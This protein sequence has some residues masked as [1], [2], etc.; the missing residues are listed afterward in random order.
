[1]EAAEKIHN[2]PDEPT[3]EAIPERGQWSGRFDFLL[4]SLGT[5]VG[6]GNVWRFPYLCY[7]NGG[8][9][10]L[11]PYVIMVFMVGL[12]VFLVELTIGQ[13]AA[14]SPLIIF[15]NIAP[16]FRGIGIAQ[17]FCA[18]FVAIYYNMIIAWTLFYF[19]E[20]FRK[21]VPWQYCDNSFNTN[22]CFDD[23]NFKRCKS[24]NINNTFFNR[25]CFNE[26]T[27]T[28]YNYSDIPQDKRISAPEEYFNLYALGKSEGLHDIGNL[29]WQLVCSL[30]GAWVIVVCC[31]IKGIKTSGRVVYFTATFPYV[32]LLILFFRGVTLDGA[33][34]GIKFYIIPNFSKLGDIGVWEDATIQV[35]YSFSIAGG[36]MI[37]YASYN[38]FHN[39]LIKDTLIIGIG[40]MLTSIF[41]GFVVFSVLGFMAHQ[42]ET[43][44]EDVVESGTGLAFIVYPDGITR[45]PLSILWGLLFFFML[46]LLGIDSQFAMVET[47]ITFA[48]DLLP[49][50]R[51]RKPLVVICIGTVLFLFGLPLCTN[52]GVYILEVIDAYAAGWPFMF[53]GLL[54]CLV[55]A[56][57]YGIEN[58]LDDLKEMTGWSPGL[59]IRSHLMTV[60]MTVSPLLIA[61]ILLLTWVK[62]E[63][64]KLGNY[65]FPPA[66]NAI[67]W[68]LALIPILCIPTAAVWELYKHR[69]I[70]II[71]RLK[72]LTKPTSE[73][74]ANARRHVSGHGVVMDMRRPLENTTVTEKEDAA[75]DNPAL[76]D[77]PPQYSCQL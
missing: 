27:S 3:V 39:N 40:D 68:I 50:T 59:W 65:V 48:F 20:C 75:Y 53:V 54:E 66:G 24:D 41:S 73:W 67:G 2:D 16:I 69:D 32:I 64:L 25:T 42:L 15:R 34:E 28:F 26:T 44:V 33:L 37:T 6:L 11:V 17:I 22:N 47:I 35:F 51:T 74:R 36:S 43:T 58:F 13:F 57:V 1:M 60:I 62:F 55:I 56:Y 52:G 49:N 4:A 77:P 30:L 71:Q 19:F 70:P 10:F 46:F 72:F 31:L 12:P 14:L 45:M 8:G 5:A 29:R 23:R 7:R 18:V 61:F 38:R 76:T 9:A 63:P 21:E